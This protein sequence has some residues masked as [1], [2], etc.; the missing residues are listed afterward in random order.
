MKDYEN[1]YDAP[2][3]G[4]TVVIRNDD[5]LGT[6][7]KV[8]NG[9][10]APYNLVT[11]LN[12]DECGWG[13]MYGSENE[14]NTNLLENVFSVDLVFTSDKSKWSRGP[15]I[16]MTDNIGSTTVAEGGA[17][18][19]NIRKHL[20]WNGQVDANDQPIYSTDPA[21]SGMSYFPGYAINIETGERLNVYFG[22]ESFN[23]QDNGNDMLW[24]PT[25]RIVDPIT[26]KS[27]WAGKH[28]IYIARSKY[29]AGAAF[30]A[31]IRVNSSSASRPEL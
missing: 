16:E 5:Q 8:I 4:D 17:Y 20:G 1:F 3:G 21:D 23:A 6:F 11:N 12:L 9:T 28:V 24:N 18:K 2:P 30:A 19:Y 13:L 14:R 29:D 10:F 27:K 22:E 7:E 26:F 31:N 15:V 25:T